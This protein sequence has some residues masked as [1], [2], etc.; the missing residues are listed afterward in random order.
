[1]SIRQISLYYISKLGY[2]SF[3]FST[4]KK[5][6][7]KFKISS[8]LLTFLLSSLL[9]QKKNPQFKILPTHMLIKA[10]LFVCMKSRLP[11]Y[12]AISQTSIRVAL[13][14]DFSA[15]RRWYPCRVCCTLPLHVLS[16]SVF[17]VSPS[18]GET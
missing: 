16:I 5:F 9:T 10:Y 4:K 12:N 1:M 8:T 14:I 17:S 15:S 2:L 13:A 11:I 6:N 18:R 7:T 3:S